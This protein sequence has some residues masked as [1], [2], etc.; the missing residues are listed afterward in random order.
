METEGQV[1]FTYTGADGEVIDDQATHV[2][3][4]ARVIRTRAFFQHRKIVEVICSEDVEKVESFAFYRCP[5]LRRVIMPNVKVVERS[6]FLSCEALEDVECDK[7]EIVKEYAFYWCRSL[8]SINLPSVRI[9]WNEAFYGCSLTDVKFGNKL[10]RLK[11]IAFCNCES[12]ERITI[13]FKDGLITADNIFMGCDNLH[14]V[15]LVDGEVLHE[16]IAAFQL[17]EWRY[18][19]SE[20]IDSI[21]QILPNASA[22]RW[23]GW[24]DEEEDPGE[25]AQAIRVWIISVFREIMYY[26]EEHYNLLNEAATALQLALPSEIVMNNVLSFLKLPSHSFEVDEPRYDYGY[27]G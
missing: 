8:R 18:E 20:E 23:N 17:E 13:P 19:M 10:E 12:L 21:N 6:S 2:I 5:S 1:W 15:D 4:Q 27:S 14:Q 26:Q 3:V 7:L 11:E 25:K 24:G 22:G 9:V 16:A